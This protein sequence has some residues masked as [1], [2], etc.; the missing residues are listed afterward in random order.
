MPKSRLNKHNLQGFTLME[1]MIVIVLLGVLI[2]AGLGSFV[3]SQQKGRD[4]RRKSDLRSFGEA[5]EIYYN[6]YGKY[7]NDD[8]TGRLMGCG[9]S[10]TSVCPISCSGPNW[11]AGGASGCST[12]YM[13]TLPQDPSTGRQYYYRY[14]SA[15]GSGYQLYAALENTLDPNYNASGYAGTNCVTSGTMLCTYGISSGNLTP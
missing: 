7:P 9:T 1:L 14:S 15:N 10:G 3:S 11:A 4:N 2:A 5:L 13:V 8:G 6:D 12:I